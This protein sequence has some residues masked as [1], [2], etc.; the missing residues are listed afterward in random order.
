MHCSQLP[1]LLNDANWLVTVPHG[2]AWAKQTSE[3]DKNW[4]IPS[5]GQRLSVFEHGSLPRSFC[6]FAWLQ[7]VILLAQYFDEEAC[8]FCDKMTEECVSRVALRSTD[9]EDNVF[10]ISRILVIETVFTVLTSAVL[11]FMIMVVAGLMLASDV[12]VR[13]C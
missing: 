7:H 6:L 10:C 1:K 3:C 13:P 2:D 5:H 12:C 9:C 11:S 4:K 8:S